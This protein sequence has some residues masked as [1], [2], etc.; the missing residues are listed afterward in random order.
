MTETGSRGA[1]LAARLRAAVD[2]ILALEPAIAAAPPLPDG[3]RLGDGEDA[4]GPREV[5]AHVTEAASYWHGE[6]ERVLAGDPSVPVPVPFGRTP[7]DV[8]RV[9]ILSRDRSLPAFVLFDRLERE[10]R[11][12]VA[13]IARMPDAELDAVGLHPVRGPESIAEV[14]ER[15]LAGHFEGHVEQLRAALGGS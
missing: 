2:A 7:S 13:R 6:I 15:T 3:A 9:A 5:L 11:S 14:I 1:L 10:A 4:W 12:L 8:A